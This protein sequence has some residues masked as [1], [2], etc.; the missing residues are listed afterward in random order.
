[1]KYSIMTLNE[2]VTRGEKHVKKKKN[3]YVNFEK[4]CYLFYLFIRQPLNSK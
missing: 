4:L 3:V 1:M 2:I